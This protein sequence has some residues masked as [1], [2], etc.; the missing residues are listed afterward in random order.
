MSTYSNKDQRG[1]SE[2]SI[3]PSSLRAEQCCTANKHK[4]HF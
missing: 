1:G 4:A 3:E 2:Y